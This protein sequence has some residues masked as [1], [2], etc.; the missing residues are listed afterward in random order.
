MN[1]VETA[2]WIGLALTTN[3]A[4]GPPKM[5]DFVADAGVA[6]LGSS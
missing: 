3:A 2:T 5:I 4:D 1:S 6:R